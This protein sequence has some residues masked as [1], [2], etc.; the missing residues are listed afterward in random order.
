MDVR[1]GVVGVPE[2]MCFRGIADRGGWVSLVA[3][4]ARCSRVGAKGALLLAPGGTI[5]LNSANM[6][7]R[8]HTRKGVRQK[9]LMR[10]FHEI[11]RSPRQ[12]AR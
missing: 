11:H 8:H 9:A 4:L 3:G 2:Y 1:G 7:L 12:G 10:R 6:V 5:G